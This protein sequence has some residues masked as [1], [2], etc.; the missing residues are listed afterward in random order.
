MSLLKAWARKEMFRDVGEKVAFEMREIAF[1]VERRIFS[2]SWV[3]FVSDNLDRGVSWSVRV[4]V[5]LLFPVCFFLKSE[6]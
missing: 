2:S 6:D 3:F 1:L 5:E 4:H